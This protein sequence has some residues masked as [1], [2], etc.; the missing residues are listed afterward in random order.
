M[1]TFDKLLCG[2]Y[3]MAITKLFPLSWYREIVFDHITYIPRIIFRPIETKKVQVQN[4]KEF[5]NIFYNKLKEIYLFSP[6]GLKAFKTLNNGESSIIPSFDLYE[7]YVLYALAPSANRSDSAISNISSMPFNLHYTSLNWCVLNAPMPANTKC[8]AT[9]TATN[10]RVY[11]ACQ[12]H[13]IAR[14]C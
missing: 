9:H 14:E 6:N 7:L 10:T 5:K 4:K 13:H 3:M 11:R 2:R 12:L 8:R 1:W